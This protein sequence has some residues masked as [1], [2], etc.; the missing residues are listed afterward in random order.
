[1]TDRPILFS[2]PMVRAIIEERKTQTRRVLRI[3]EGFSFSGTVVDNIGKIH[4]V[5]ESQYHDTGTGR[6]APYQVG[7]RL[8]VREAF[9][10]S[11]C[12]WPPHYM[13][14]G[15][16]PSISERHDAGLLKVHPSI[17][18]PRRASRL[19]LGVTAVRVQR[20]Q[21]ISEDDAKAEGIERL[22]SGRGYYDPTVPKAAVRF[23]GY[24]RTAVNA[25]GALWDAINGKRPGCAWDDNPW[26]MAIT[27]KPHHCN[28]D[29]MA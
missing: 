15:P 23:G 2:G 4:V 3:P 20:L 9:A 16:L 22:R 1:M 17:H 25:F 10:D 21:D 29:Q 28:I 8:W 13:A 11:G 27:F 7:D 24:F 5:F 18:M 26:V 19:T 14:D 12:S 6:L